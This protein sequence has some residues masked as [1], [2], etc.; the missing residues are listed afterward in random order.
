VSDVVV[1]LD[2]LRYVWTGSR[3]YRQRDFLTPP[4]ATIQRLQAILPDDFAEPPPSADEPIKCP[5][6]LR[7]TWPDPLAAEWLERYP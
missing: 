7:A 5:R 6:S 2:E 1:E 4:K 3:W